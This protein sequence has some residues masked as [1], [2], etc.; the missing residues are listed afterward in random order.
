[1]VRRGRAGCSCETWP[2][3]PVTRLLRWENGKL[4]NKIVRVADR[5]LV[6]K[7]SDNYKKQKRAISELTKLNKQ[8]KEIIQS[9]V[10]SK[11][12]CEIRAIKD[13]L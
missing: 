12:D 8:E 3:R 10:K 5:E 2:V 6:R 7:L 4:K 9:V 1:M 13:E 11:I